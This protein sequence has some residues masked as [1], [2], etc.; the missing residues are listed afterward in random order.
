MVFPCLCLVPELV[1]AANPAIEALT[2][3]DIQFSLAHFKQTALF[4]N[5]DDYKTIHQCSGFLGCDSFIKRAGLMG[6]GVD[7]LIKHL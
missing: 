6:A 7:N 4:K 3:Q 2:C 5:I 1:K